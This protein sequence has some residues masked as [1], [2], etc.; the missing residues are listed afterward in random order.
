MT[1]RVH[2]GS[3]SFHLVAITIAERWAVLALVVALLEAR[4]EVAFA[5]D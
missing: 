5:S 1:R 3:V 4:A 2:A